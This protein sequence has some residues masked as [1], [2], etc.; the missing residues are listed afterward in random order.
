MTSTCLRPYRV[1][2]GKN[3]F[4]SF[5]PCNSTFSWFN[6]KCV[7]QQIEIMQEIFTFLENDTIYSAEN[8]KSKDCC[9]IEIHSDT[10]NFMKV[11]FQNLLTNRK[12]LLMNKFLFFWFTSNAK[13]LICTKFNDF[14]QL[15]LSIFIWSHQQFRKKNWKFINT[16]NKTSKVSDL[17][18]KPDTNN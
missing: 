16:Y 7:S 18:L 3:F 2:S 4:C 8:L 9:V 17:L 5:N 13:A 15:N 14:F 1:K 10:L 6:P 12:P 11:V